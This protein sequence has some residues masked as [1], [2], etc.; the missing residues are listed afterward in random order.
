[1]EQYKNEKLK[2]DEIM[3]QSR[4]LFIY[5]KNTDYRSAFLRKM[6][7]EYPIKPDS[8]SPMGLYFDEFSLPII[9]PQAKDLDRDRIQIVGDEYFAFTVA[10]KL[11]KTTKSL[12]IRDL[13]D[14][15]TH[16][17]KMLDVRTSDELMREMEK[18]IKF[19]LNYYVNY[20]KGGEELSI[21]GL[22]IP[23]INLE[24]FVI[25]YKKAINNSSYL[26]IVLDK[27][28]Q[29]AIP[30]VKAVNTH[31]G[32]RINSDISMK[33]VTEP[34]DWETSYDTRGQIV[35]RV[36]D[37]GTVELDDSNKEFLLKLKKERERHYGQ[38]T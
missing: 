21:N 10:Y 7:A 9:K 26:A 19:Y 5:G 11:I 35:E 29:L 32:S 14:R 2:K 31:V 37:Y 36:H 24:S 8:D 15:L 3:N 16:L 30:S 38:W 17:L 18:T 28:Q 22:K 33:V 4:H 27:K 1:M 6:T 12:N 20:L 13:E 34:E 25:D 23:F